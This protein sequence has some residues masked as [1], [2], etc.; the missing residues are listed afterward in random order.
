MIMIKA[1]FAVP[2]TQQC[3]EHNIWVVR[4]EIEHTIM[5][6][7]HH[8]Y[9]YS[10][11]DSDPNTFA[12]NLEVCRLNTRIYPHDDWMTSYLTIIRNGYDFCTC[13]SFRMH[14]IPK[15]IRQNYGSKCKHI[16]LWYALYDPSILRTLASTDAIIQQP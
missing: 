8:D 5:R 2:N 6:N 12:F 1:N 13:K 16:M 4:P 9:T 15:L 7:N 11:L 14:S 3:E 10:V